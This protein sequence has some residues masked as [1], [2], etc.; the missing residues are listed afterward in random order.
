[1]NAKYVYNQRGFLLL[2]HLISI[3]ITGI[4]SIA[5]LTIMQ[6]I[7]GYTVNQ[8]ALTMQEVNTIAIRLQNEARFA[9]A[10][11]VSAGR[12]DIH[13]NRTNQTVSFFVLNNNLVRRVDGLGGE[14][15]VYN[16]ASLDVIAVDANQA[17]LRLRCLAENEFAFYVSRLRLDIA[18]FEEEFNDEELEK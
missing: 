18:T 9:D 6:V 16:V 12:L 5:F 15:L 7:A 8:N 14:I 13:F 10:L 1:M 2:E 11:T 17:R 4:I 3:A